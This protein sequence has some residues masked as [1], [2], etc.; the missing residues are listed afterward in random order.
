MVI[1]HLY[2]GHDRTFF[3]ADY[4]GLRYATSR[5][6]QYVVP[7]A[8]EKI[9]RLL[10]GGQRRSPTRFTGRPYPG[11]AKLTPNPSSAALLSLFPAANLHVG[12]AVSQVLQDPLDA[13]QLSLHQ[14]KRHRL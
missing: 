10:A 8:Q 6:V 13:L 11:P 4:E 9:R 7:T 5:V 12:E 1:P 14:A 3:F 2:N